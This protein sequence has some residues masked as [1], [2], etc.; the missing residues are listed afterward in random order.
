MQF[1]EVSE[2]LETFYSIHIAT[3][4][5]HKL[6]KEEMAYMSREEKINAL[7]NPEVRSKDVENPA[8]KA[9]NE[10]SSE[11]LAEIQGASDVNPETTP[12]CIAASI[13]AT[14]IFSV[15]NC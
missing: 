6:K 13:G 14:I 2:K 4:Y 10:L 8:G 5:Q 11:E 15:R 7:K 1:C 12:L 3:T 9:M